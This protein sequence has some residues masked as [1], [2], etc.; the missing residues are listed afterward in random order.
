MRNDGWWDGD[1][2]AKSISKKIAKEVVYN[3]VAQPLGLASN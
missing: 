3:M 1:V 2:D